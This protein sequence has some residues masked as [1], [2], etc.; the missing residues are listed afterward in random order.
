MPLDKLSDDIF[1][2][3]QKRN[4]LNHDMLQVSNNA[5]KE[6]RDCLISTFLICKYFEL[7]IPDKDYSEFL[8]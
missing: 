6:L 3:T 1:K 2:L 4:S 5:K 8:Q 7:E